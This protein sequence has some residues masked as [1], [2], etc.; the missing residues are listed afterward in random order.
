MQKVNRAQP[1]AAILDE[2]MGNTFMF[3]PLFGQGVNTNTLEMSDLAEVSPHQC[4]PFAGC[5]ES[6][7]PTRAT[8]ASAVISV[9]VPGWIFCRIR[10]NPK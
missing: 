9:S 4:P 2:A 7:L 8:R 5:V 10:L 1:V 6:A 3:E